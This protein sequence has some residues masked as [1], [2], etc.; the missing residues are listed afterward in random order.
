MKNFAQNW[1]DI[2]CKTIDGICS[3]LFLLSDKQIKSLHP[4]AQ[5]PVDSQE[6]L[7]LIAISK[8]AV[9]RNKNVLNANISNSKLQKAFDYYAAPI[10]VDQQLIGTIAV[11]TA[12]QTKDKQQ[13]IL[14]GLD[15]GAKWLEFSQPQQGDAPQEFYTTVVRLAAVCLDQSSYHQAISALITE[16]TSQFECDRVSIGEIQDHHTQVIA[17]SNSAKFDSRSNLFRTIAGA[18]D[19]AVDQDEIIV[20]PAL[21]NASDS[22]NHA[23]AELARKF[24]SGSICTIPLVDDDAIFAILTLERSEERPFDREAVQICEQ[25]MALVSPFLKL[26]RADEQ[27]LGE[28]IMAA[29]KKRL[30]DF[31]GLQHLGIKFCALLLLILFC[32]AGLTE[33]DFR[34]NAD[35]VLE[36]RVQRTISAPIEGFISSAAVRAGDTVKEGEIM[37]A[38][39]DT[40]LK[41]EKL[42]LTSEQQQLQREY[43]EAMADRDLVQVRVLNAQIAQIAAQIKLKQEQLQRTKITAPFAGIVIEGDLSQSLGSPVERGSSLFKIA[44]L[45]GYRIILKVNERSI[46]Y[47]R[48]GQSGT[49]A[50]S[51]MPNRKFSLRVEKI[52]AVANADDGSNIFR[53]EAALPGTPKLLRPGMEGVGKIDIGREKLLWIWT[54]ELVDWIRL[55]VWSWWP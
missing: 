53:V 39:E 22:I 31:F 29:S 16:L 21:E 49:L 48:H 43:R 17:L 26:K 32:Y 25:T 10:I 37:A 30:S 50:L 42:K 6:P 46:S 19:E 51:S 2:Q 23:H 34:I 44:P 52:T 13:Q 15:M 18:M 1:L 27:W 20:Y 9:K 55:W 41:L 4:A 54:H 5:W 12:S 45:E 8:Q 33:G 28:K 40:D 7:E 47:I 11:K 38:M 24:G 3:A 36:G 14:A 35:A